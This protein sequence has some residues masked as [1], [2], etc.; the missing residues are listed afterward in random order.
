MKVLC[1]PSRC[2][3][4]SLLSQRAYCVSALATILG[5]ILSAVLVV[6]YLGNLKTGPLKKEYF[7]VQKSYVANMV[8]IGA[9][10]SLNQVAMLL[11]QVVLNSSL[12][13]YGELSVYGSSEALA[14]AGVVAK[15]NMI[16]YSVIIGFSIGC[17]PIMGFNYGAKQWDRVK[18]GVTF[19]LKSCTLI[20]TVGGAILYALA[21]QIVE[22]FRDDPTVIEI[23]TAMFRYQCLVLPTF[24]VTVFSNMLF[25][26]VGKS[27]RA[28]VLA[29]CRPGILIPAVFL[30]SE[31]FGLTGLE[32]AQPAA[33][34]IS[35]CMAAII[36]LH[37][38]T[39]EFGKE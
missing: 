1:E 29:V 19:S 39:R 23:G 17:E 25:Q 33:D 21:P 35:F 15:V 3:I 11:S 6:R 34:L 16:F 27:W 31:R 20:L 26:A 22:L 4:V 18:Q 30:L 2:R 8:K 37:Y 14:A 7:K 10:A 28:S 13:H 36:M 24:A 12:R 32:L 5:Q 9:A 38:F